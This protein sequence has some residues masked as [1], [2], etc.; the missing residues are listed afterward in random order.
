MYESHKQF[1]TAGSHIHEIDLPNMSITEILRNKNGY[2]E[3]F[4]KNLQI[5]YPLQKYSPK[6]EVYEWP[7]KLE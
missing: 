2:V 5:F 7:E 4:K 3:Y 1:E 6:V